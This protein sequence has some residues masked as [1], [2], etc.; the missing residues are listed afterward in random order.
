MLLTEDQRAGAAACLQAQQRGAGA[1]LLC[2][3]A[4]TGK[5]FLARQLLLTGLPRPIAATAPTHQAVSVLRDAVGDTADHHGTIHSLLGLRPY[6]DAF[7]RSK[8][9]RGGANKLPQFGTVLLD[10][11]SM[12]GSELRTW[13]DASIRGTFLLALG[14]PY[15]LPP[16][17]ER[18]SPYWHAI[19]DQFALHT[20]VRQ[21]EG[22]EIRDITQL[23]VAQQDAGAI[24]LEWTYPK[25]RPRAPYRLAAH[26][27]FATDFATMAEVFR[28]DAYRCDPR[29]TRVLTYTNAAVLRYNRRL[30]E[31]VLGKTETPFVPGELVLTR[32]PIGDLNANGE[33]QIIVPVNAELRL[34]E[35]SAESH[36]LT[37]GGPGFHSGAPRHQEQN[38]PVQVWRLTLIDAGGAVHVCRMPRKPGVRELLVER[39]VEGQRWADRRR[40]LAAF[41]DLRHGYASTVHCAQGATFDS[42]FVDVED[43]ARP[44][45]NQDD[46]LT[47]LQLLYVAAS[48]PR[49]ALVLAPP[50]EETLID[51]W[52]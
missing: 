6:E 47:R 32:S 21:A 52:S 50:A 22:N 51:L 48:R 24:D 18:R 4:G 16:I 35:I 20:V 8:L 15:Q 42:V 46:T 17:E 31:A 23:L 28:S 29:H 3:P 14:D 33:L 39:C 34:A 41:P 27:V 9:R 1:F 26:G 49:H 43:I 19:K 44:R 7:G 40:V 38:L 10:E 36:V 2:G 37:L 45:G 11:L 5:T 13:I 12:I 30:R 25:G